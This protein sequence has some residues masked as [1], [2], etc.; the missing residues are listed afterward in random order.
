MHSSASSRTS[1]SR[2]NLAFPFYHLRG[3]SISAVSVRNST[4]GVIKRSGRILTKQEMTMLGD[5]SKTLVDEAT[6]FVDEENALEILHF[7]TFKSPPASYRRAV[8]T[9]NRNVECPFCSIVLQ[10]SHIPIIHKNRLFRIVCEPPTISLLNPTSL[11]PG[12]RVPH[13]EMALV[14][15]RGL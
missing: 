7:S 12:L 9:E 5:K 14:A 13:R 4:V 3:P 11:L 10:S 8:P 15:R 2:W 6:I 1:E